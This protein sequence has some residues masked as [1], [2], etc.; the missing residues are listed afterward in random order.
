MKTTPSG[1]IRSFII[2]HLPKHSHDIVHQAA[3]SL[4][5]TRTTVHRH[6]NRLLKE[7]DV[8]KTGTKKGCRYHLKR[9]KNKTFTFSVT[10]EL[11]E[12]GIWKEYFLD[13][14]MPIKYNIR[15]ICEY[16]FTEILN[17]AIEHAHAKSIQT[18]SN[19]QKN[20][21]TLTIRDDGIG[22][23]RKLLLAF[24]L[25]EIKE[26]VLEV[27]KGKVTTDPSR[28]TGEGLFFTGR[29][30]DLFSLKSNGILFLRDN[31]AEDWSL[32]TTKGHYAGTEVSMG[33]AL[34]ADGN[35]TRLFQQYQTPETL[36]FSKT[37]IFVKLAELG[38]ER[39]ISRSQAKRILRG[40]EQFKMIIL[41]FKDV[42]MVGQGFV[43]EVFRV[44]ARQNPQI[45][46]TYQNANPDVQFMI[47]R[48][49]PLT[50]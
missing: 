46:I 40:L 45:N 32:E 21:V 34:N 42:E 11:D 24:H 22:I 36:E 41:D 15:S 26:S 3:E 50:R 6:L 48:G 13:D 4:R 35:L 7:G 9:E 38:G 30:F 18:S 49:L 17:N 8:I 28:H 43:D 25:N 19:W 10:P 39:F 27:T 16:G 2:K 31:L 29:A 33:I 14:F 20:Y 1:A 12:F 37:D 44:F 23:F 47:K 5:V